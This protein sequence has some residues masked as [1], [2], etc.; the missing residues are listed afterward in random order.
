MKTSSR[1]AGP[2]I[3]VGAEARTPPPASEVRHVL[4]SYPRC[5]RTL[6]AEPRMKTS[7]RPV[8]TVTAAGPDL[9]V[10]ASDSQCQLPSYQSCQSAL[11]VPW[12]NTSNRLAP[13]ETAA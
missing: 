9:R 12:A 4:E 10:P 6:S 3:A 7:R 1:L 5:Q 11:S 2:V 13:H 8:P